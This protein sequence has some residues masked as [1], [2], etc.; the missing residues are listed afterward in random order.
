LLDNNDYSCVGTDISKTALVFA[1]DIK[2]VRV[3]SETLPFRDNYFDGVLAIS[4]I[5]HLPKPAQCAKEVSRVLKKNG[6]F[7]CITP[8]RGSLLGKFGFRLVN[9]TSL[10]NPYHV[11]LMNRA[12]LNLILKNAGFEQISINPLHN[13]FYGAPFVK[14]VFRQDVIPIPL[15]VPIPFSPHQ[16]AI[17][18]KGRI[19]SDLQMYVE[20]PERTPMLVNQQ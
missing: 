11:G 20:I 14:K 15:K 3:D 19:Q 17:A 7:I 5:E 16:I 18:Y 2:T 9:Y 4:T 13:G 8:D 1:K 12:E 6:L 10:K